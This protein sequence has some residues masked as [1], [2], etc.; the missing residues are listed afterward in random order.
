MT[1]KLVDIYKTKFFYKTMTVDLGYLFTSMK[2]LMDKEDFEPNIGNELLGQIYE[3]VK[4]GEEVRIDLA[5]ARLTSDALVCIYRAEANGI[6][7]C[8]SLSQWRDTIFAENRLRA[9]VKNTELIQ[10]PVFGY[11]TDIKEYVKGLNNTILYDCSGQPAHI[12]IA[13]TCIIAILRPSVN[14]C[15]DKISKTLFKYINTKVPT[16]EILSS[17]EFFMCTDEGVQIV[18]DGNIYVQEAQS[19][20]SV[21]E[22]LQ[23]A[24]LVPTKFGKEVLLSNPAY[25]GLFRSCLMMLQ[26]FQEGSS[27]T[28][29]EIYG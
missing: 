28:L 9:Q 3:A 18:K 29:E 27:K 11:R 24:V 21:K 19:Y 6:I 12:L 23:Y 26:E 15:I 20:L 8:D 7:F 5:D 10:L 1:V 17:S 4:R 25:N 14:L 13:L 16:S 2:R 22:A